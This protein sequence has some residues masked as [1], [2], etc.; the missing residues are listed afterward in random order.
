[1]VENE[2]QGLPW[3][4]TLMADWQL[5]ADAAF[6]DLVL[7][8][9]KRTKLHVYAHARPSTAATLF[10]RD[11]TGTAARTDWRKAIDEAW[12]TG[13]PVLAS[14]VSEYTAE[15]PA[16]CRPIRYLSQRRLRNP[17]Q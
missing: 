1:M 12:E 11:I 15:P 14:E 13:K 8:V 2:L 17:S 5:I 7:W 16:D 10:Y 3:I 9:P 4:R 6:S